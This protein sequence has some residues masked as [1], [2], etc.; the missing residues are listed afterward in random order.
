MAPLFITDSPA[1]FPEPVAS[2]TKAQEDSEQPPGSRDG[3]YLLCW[4]LR[5]SEATLA[6]LTFALRRQP[7]RISRLRGLG[8]SYSTCEAA[9]EAQE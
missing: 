4:R 9:Q 2:L 6:L 8:R 1:S 3:G 5:L 7:C